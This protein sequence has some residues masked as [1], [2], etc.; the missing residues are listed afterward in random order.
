MHMSTK[1]LGYLLR[2]EA[3]DSD[4]NRASRFAG[5]YNYFGKVHGAGERMPSKGITKSRIDRR[6]KDTTVVSVFIRASSE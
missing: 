2:S 6:C 1:L 3:H 4:G 5:A